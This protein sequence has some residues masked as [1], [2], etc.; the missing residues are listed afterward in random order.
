[1]SVGSN[2]RMGTKAR[3]PLSRLL[4]WTLPFP[5]SDQ[6]A[7]SPSSCPGP[8]PSWPNLSPESP[9]KSSLSVPGMRRSTLVSES[10]KHFR[11]GT[12]NPTISYRNLLL[13]PVLAS[14]QLDCNFL[15][16]WQGSNVSFCITHGSKQLIHIPGGNSYGTFK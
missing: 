3:P 13:F 15:Q 7:Q 5:P 8:F 16:S 4:D 12:G 14:V 6:S 11:S 2:V 10:L 1:M 9:K